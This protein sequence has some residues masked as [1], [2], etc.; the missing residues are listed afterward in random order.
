MSAVLLGPPGSA[1]RRTLMAV[2]VL[3]LAVSALPV[4]M[5]VVMSFSAGTTLD[6]PPASFSLRWYESA[7]QVLASDDDGVLSAWGSLKTSL[8]VAALTMLVSVA[9]CVP[10][11]YAMS[12]SNGPWRRWAEV[13]FAMPMVFPLVVLGLAFLLM[14]ERWAMST[15]VEP[16]LWRLVIPHITLALPFV[17]R[18]CLS[19]MHGIGP[20]VEEAA[21]SL[22]ASPLRAFADI[23]VP[24][25]KPG[26][27]AGL[28]FAFIISFNEFTVTF[29]MYTVDV[30]TL[31][32]WMYSRTTSALDPTTLA[33][34][35]LVIVLD[36][37]LI[38][39]VDKL[40]ANKGNVF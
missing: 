36:V 30:R 25:M 26:I 17:L 14:A 16:G 31:T 38:V 40:L 32:I 22:G 2:A 3:G 34:S 35:T 20:E 12:R 13:A 19:A 6:F 1:L 5:I 21:M 7:W 33:I 24:M 4:L 37:L 9:V 11:A 10:L 39:W 29:F 15:G 18:N 28:I 8:I 23:V 27:L